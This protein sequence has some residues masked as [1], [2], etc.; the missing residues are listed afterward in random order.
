VAISRRLTGAAALASGAISLGLLAAAPPR[1]PLG[2]AGWLLAAVCVA[3]T[4]TGAL[5]TLRAGSDADWNALVAIQWVGLGSLAVLV[6]LTG[7][8]E[9]PQ[10]TLFCS[11]SSCRPPA[12]P[13][14]APAST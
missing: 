8:N 4:L 5:V 10:T 9:S 13:R 2:D 12:T 1:G 11:G 14:A 3:V 6:W 7:G